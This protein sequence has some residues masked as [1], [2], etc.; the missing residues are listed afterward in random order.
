MKTKQLI[1]YSCSRQIAFASGSQSI[2]DHKRTA[3]SSQAFASG[4]QHI[5]GHKMT[6]DSSPTLTSGSEQNVVS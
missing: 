2:A 5:V 1:V 3:D 4:S 6:A